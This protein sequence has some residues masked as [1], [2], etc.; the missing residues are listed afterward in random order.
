MDFNDKVEKSKENNSPAI[1]KC[2][3]VL[4]KGSLIAALSFIQ[5]NYEF[6]SIIIINLYAQGVPLIQFV[7]L[8]EQLKNI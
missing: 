6:V 8:V 3:A 2:Q 4:K 5:S 1:R 7:G